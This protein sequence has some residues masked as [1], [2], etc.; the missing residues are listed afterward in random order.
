MRDFFFPPGTRRRRIVDGTAASR[1]LI[2]QEGW[3]SFWEKSKEK[4]REKIPLRFRSGDLFQPRHITPEN[5][6]VLFLIYPWAELTNRYRVYNMADYL[7]DAGIPVEIAAVDAIEKKV[8]WVLRFDVVVIHRIPLYP[9]LGRFIKKCR[10]LGIPVVF[11]LDDYIFDL[12][13]IPR[14]E[15]MNRVDKRER[16]KWM[17]HFRGCRETLQAADYFFGTTEFLA[18]KAG[19][20]GPTA[21]VL[22]NG[23]NTVQIQES[24]KALQERRNDP[25]RIYLGYFSGTKTHQKDFLQIKSVL[26]RI[27]EEYPRVHLMVGGF[28]E[29]DPDF[30]RFSD[31][32]QQIPFVDWRELPARM[33]TIEVNLVPLEIGNPFNEAKSELKYF[34]PALLKIPTVASPTDAFRWAIKHGENGYLAA[35]E[36]EWYAALVD[37]IRDKE[38]RIKIG[39]AAYHHVLQ[40]YTPAAQACRVKEVY[41]DMIRDYRQKQG[42][43]THG[44]FGNPYKLNVLKT[45]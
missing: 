9:A 20:L 44:P 21:F 26:I 12:D 34:E 14:I 3:E 5:F 19:E 32:L 27:L 6:S 8:S 28:I 31:R 41:Q 36:A 38:L 7:R 25:D 13:L 16:K 17:A 22:R 39:E 37:L 15:L 1:K 43:S 45:E 35:T 11:D 23:L 18:R 33:K 4:F 2:Q 30:Q 40:T 29:M 42:L 10:T 24:Q